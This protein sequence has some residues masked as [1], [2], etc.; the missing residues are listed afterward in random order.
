MAV[1]KTY[2]KRAAS[3][4]EAGVSSHA[5]AEFIEDLHESG[6]ETHS[7]MI[8]R[9]GQVAFESWSRPYGPDIPHAMY[10]VSKSFTST[11]VC[12]AVEEGLL[13]LETKVIDIFPEFRP[14]KRDENLEKLTVYHLLTMTAGKDVSLLSDRTKNRWVKNFI[15][16]KWNFAPGSSW[17]YMNDNIYLLCAILTRVTGMTVTDYLMPRLFEPLGF[18]RKPFWETDPGGVEA[19]GWGLFLTTE[20][21]AKFSLCYLQGGVYEGKQVI[22][23][24]WVKEATKKQVNTTR[25]S[26]DGSV[27]YGFCFWQNSCPD[28]YR[29]DGMFSQFGIVFKEHNAVLVVT[30][31]E[32]EEQKF[33]NCIWRHFPGAFIDSGTELLRNG[34]LTA[35]PSLAP[36]EELASAPRSP[37]EKKIAGREIMIER[38]RLL[39]I[40]KQPLSMLP[41]TV[42]YM[43]AEKAGNIDKIKFSFGKN[44][45]KMSWN[46]GRERNTIICGMDG[47]TRTNPIMLAGIRFTASCTAAWKDEKTLSV[48]M[49]PLESVCQRRVDFIF[50]GDSVKFY[51]SSCPDTKSILITLSKS[52]GEYVKNPY[53]IKT[54]QNVMLNGYKIVEPVHSGR[55][56][57]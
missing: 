1:E 19:G 13:T 20:E 17:Q 44:E 21:L 6:M 53:A 42:V 38:Q 46:E 25:K 16:S 18:G 41:I 39:D 36:L 2:L 30:A 3:P 22:P 31:S 50:N 51:L 47:K 5:I 10:S 8:L 14:A 57:Q 7:I 48:W 4:E 15:D 28:S 43:T 29:A 27:G 26:K 55:F 35:K 12:F 32:I 56:I 23:E 34:A 37:L 40:A 52:V 9:G 33:R 49:R 24:K 45:C 54:V 11:A